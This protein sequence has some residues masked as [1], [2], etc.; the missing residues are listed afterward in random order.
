MKNVNLFE[1]ECLSGERWIKDGVMDGILLF[2]LHH[3]EKTNNVEIIKASFLKEIMTNYPDKKDKLI[4]PNIK[5]K[6]SSINKT[7]IIF[8][9]VGGGHWSVLIF[10]RP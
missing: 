3:H 9:I 7:V 10:L 2:F 4:N 6:G 5:P 1:F 8:P